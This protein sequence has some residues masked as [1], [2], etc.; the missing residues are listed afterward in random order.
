MA[1][2][3]G[4]ARTPA[5]IFSR[6]T[7][8]VI[9]VLFALLIVCVALAWNSRDA[10]TQL[11]F[12]K[13]KAT[14]GNAQATLVDL[15]PW[16][17]AQ[18]LAAMA[19]TAEELEYAREA[20]RLADQEVDQAF[21]S[22]LRQAQAA[23]QHRALTGPAL[24]LS[25]KVAALQQLV[26]ADQQRSSLAS[27]ASADE[28]DMAKAQLDLDTDELND[29]QQD[30]ARLLGDVRTRIQQELSAHQA[31]MKK[32]DAAATTQSQSAIATS[33]HY[34]S[35]AQRLSAWMDQRTR[36]QLLQEAAHQAET[37][38]TALTATHNQ[39]EKQS[40]SPPT[41]VDANTETRLKQMKSRSMR[42]QML[43]IYDDRID[44]QQQLAAVYR[45]WSAQVLL[46]HGILFH[47]LMQSFALVLSIVLG[48]LLV[49]SLLRHFVDRHTADRRRLHT[50]HIVV[51]LSIQLITA[52]LILLAIFGTPS[53]MPTIVGLTTA[54]L[55]V[56]LQ[57]FIVSF[58]GWFILMGK[59]GIRIGDW[60]EI[61]GVGGEVVDV[62]IFRTTLLEIGNWTDHGHPT[63][64]RVTFINSFAVKGQ[65]FN[66]STTG[67]WMWDELTV[68]VAAS[69][70]AYAT[71]ALIHKAVLQETQ[72]ESRLAEEEWKRLGRNN[73]L[74]QFSA[75]PAVN[76]RPGALGIDILVR[77]VTRAANRYEVRNRLYQKV[78]E[79][80]HK[81]PT[82]AV[83]RSAS[84]I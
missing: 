58:C 47:L 1:Q 23:A 24:A 66:F 84:S 75:E 30:L 2:N 18:E 53:E 83:E 35:L 36:Y 54:G 15:H 27:S 25:Q 80:L 42:S 13:G 38:A 60:V 10:M 49:H 5:A 8:V 68:N 63:G 82:A 3:T 28:A 6:L 37:D 12:L 59:N 51:R 62:G 40:N 16:Q 33:K 34:G 9:A 48:A 61:N 67:Q 17:T 31:S 78:I 65:Y 57:D 76:L 69:P 32:H 46:Q 52:V 19:V 70:E 50:L 44:T 21:A 39:M 72:D 29:A 71:V 79:L 45:K 14:S 22:A 43:S 4:K 64:R 73:T 26:R 77:Y 41:D 11:A 55:T 81:P 74:N 56:V 7:L 20:Q